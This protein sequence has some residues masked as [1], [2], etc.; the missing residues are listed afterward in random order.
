MSLWHRQD[1]AD[2]FKNEIVLRGIEY[3]HVIQAKGESGERE[4]ARQ[5]LHIP[6][7]PARGFYLSPDG[8]TFGIGPQHIRHLLPQMM[9]GSAVCLNFAL[10]PY[11]LSPSQDEPY[12]GVIGEGAVA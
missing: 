2:A 10:S 7:A 11:L 4:P 6:A 5:S 1:K 8:I 3:H 9:K 12:G